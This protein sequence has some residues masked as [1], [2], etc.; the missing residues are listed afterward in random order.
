MSKINYTKVSD[1]LKALSNAKRLEILDIV[2]EKE[3]GVNDLSK[4]I[5]TRKSNTSQHLAILRY[6]GFIKARRDGKNVYYRSVD[7][8]VSKILKLF[9]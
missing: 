8:K 4:L 7:S 6:L 5:G 1:Y 9:K 2:A 3:V